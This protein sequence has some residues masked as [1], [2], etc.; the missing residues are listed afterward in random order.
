MKEAT[1][2]PAEAAVR[3]G[4]A[5][6][7]CRKHGWVHPGERL[8]SVGQKGR[9]RGQDA[10]QV[11]S[12]LMVQPLCSRLLSLAGLSLSNDQKYKS[13]TQCILGD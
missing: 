10:C 12:L 7:G 6:D 1:R 3:A 9:H 2:H 8:L 11:E 13:A 5:A 4:A